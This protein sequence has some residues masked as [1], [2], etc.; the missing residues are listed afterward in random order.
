[1][2]S[3]SWASFLFV[4]CTVSGVKRQFQAICECDAKVVNLFDV[5]IRRWLVVF[6]FVS[7]IEPGSFVGVGRDCPLVGPVGIGI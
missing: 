1:M 3:V 2:M 4:K 5:D 7:S 6:V